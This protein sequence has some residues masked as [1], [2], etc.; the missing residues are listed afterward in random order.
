MNITDTQKYLV[1]GKWFG[2]ELKAE[3]QKIIKSTN[4]TEAFCL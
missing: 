4:Q 2:Y 1:S 3:P